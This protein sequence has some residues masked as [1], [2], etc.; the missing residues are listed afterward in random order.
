MRSFTN[1][2]VKCPNERTVLVGIVHLLDFPNTSLSLNYTKAIVAC[3]FDVI[4]FFSNHGKTRK[5]SIDADMVNKTRKDSIDADM[6]N[7]T[8]KDS[9][10]A[11][12]ANKTRTA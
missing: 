10:D 9:I 2:P 4:L 3:T 12:M 7:K 11:D 1:T 5:D 6:V 8:R